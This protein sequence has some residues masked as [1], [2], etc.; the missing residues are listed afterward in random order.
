[1][2]QNISDL[3]RIAESMDQKF[4]GP[5]GWRFG[6]D[7]IIGLF[8]IV[9]DLITN[10]VS[11]YVIARAAQIGCPPSV[12]ARMGL[13]LLI[14][15]IID[16]IPFV[17]NLFDFFWKANSKNIRLVEQ[18]TENPAS[19]QN[20]SRFVLALAVFT[21]VALVVGSIAVSIIALR[22]VILWIQNSQVPWS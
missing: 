10:S 18:F 20:R 12:I 15:N 16:V 6:W 5:F 21:I 11:L 19:V 1:M 14:E 4:K 7:G 13:N 17:G 9:G 3:R 2:K 22:A 8:P